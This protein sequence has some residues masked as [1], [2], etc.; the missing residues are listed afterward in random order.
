MNN[1]KCSPEAVIG[2]SR[3]RPGTG[4]LIVSENPLRFTAALN[5]LI[6]AKANSF[7]SLLRP[8]L[9]R[10]GHAVTQAT[11]LIEAISQLSANSF[12]LLI[13]DLYLDGSAGRSIIEVCRT[14]CPACKI[15][16]AT[17]WARGLVVP[18]VG[19]SGVDYIVSAICRPEE[20][21]S[22]LNRIVP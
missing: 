3:E 4:D 7:D 10:Q 19:M 5:V 15:I 1:G 6:G 2:D 16:A 20:V 22:I 13:T 8:D 11:T 9:E 12:D 17:T 21:M 18:D 14:T